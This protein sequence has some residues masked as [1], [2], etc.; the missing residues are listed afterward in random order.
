MLSFPKWL[1]AGGIGGLIGAAIWAGI[2]YATNYE[3]GWI[4]WAIGGLVGAAVRISA[5]ESEEGFAPGLT[6]AVVAIASVLGGKYA[7][8]A[9]LVASI[10]GSDLPLEV[11]ADDMVVSFAD[12]IAGERIARGQSVAFAGGKTIET[13]TSQADYPA[14]IW[15]QASQKWQAIGPAEQQKQM[16][17]RREQMQQLATLLEGSLSSFAPP[18]SETFSLYDA[19]WFFL[20][21]ATA[22]KLGHGNIASDDD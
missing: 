3:I 10:S 8:Y 13:A 9:L 20:A 18:F 17:E 22:Y 19:L 4:A 7:A 5:G 6:A 16:A 11:N 14:D 21:A 15:Q 2:S 1:I 12:D